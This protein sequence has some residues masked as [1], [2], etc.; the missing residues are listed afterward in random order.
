MPKRKSYEMAVESKIRILRDIEYSVVGGQPLTGTLYLPEGDGPFRVVIAVHGGGWKQGSPDRYRH[1]GQWLAERGVAL[2]A[3]RYRLTDRDEHRFPAPAIDVASALRFVYD[4]AERL[5]VDRNRIALMGDSAGAHLV[6]LV[7]LANPLLFAPGDKTGT[8]LDAIR[9]RAVIGVYGV[10]DL[11][12]QWEHDQVAR[13]MDQITEALMGFSPL[14]DRIAYFHASPVAHATAKARRSA[15]LVVW[16][17]DDDVADW[18]SQSGQFIKELK[19]T[20]QFVRP[21]PVVG[22]PH[23]WIDQPIDEACS[24]TGFVAPKLLRFI[25]EHV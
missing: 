10:Y 23:F 11:L 22:A 20:G 25:N 16:G 12:A 19:R 4:S 8:G 2:F 15:F 21:V 14:D 17:T 24:F 7:A 3:I 6:S 1:W 13:P 9:I 18:R 5:G